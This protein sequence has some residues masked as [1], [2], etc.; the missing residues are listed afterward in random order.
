[1][2]ALVYLASVHFRELWNLPPR[3]WYSLEAFQTTLP[4]QTKL[5]GLGGVRPEQQLG[6][7]HACPK[8]GNWVMRMRAPRAALGD[9]HALPERHH[10]E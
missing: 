4:T 3:L 9:A 8:R 1:M 5:L 7:A 2:I 6:N 10:P